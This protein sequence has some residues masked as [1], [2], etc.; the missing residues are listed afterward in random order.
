MAIMLIYQ[1]KSNFI[2]VLLWRDSKVNPEPM[3]RH[4]LFVFVVSDFHLFYKAV[5][6]AHRLRNCL[7]SMSTLV[8]DGPAVVDK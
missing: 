1:L 4:L 3:R 6:V 8:T 2:S 5:D 7:N